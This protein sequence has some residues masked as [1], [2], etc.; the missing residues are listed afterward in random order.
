MSDQNFGIWKNKTKEG[1][2]YLSGTLPVIGEFKLYDNGEPEAG[3]KRPRYSLKISGGKVQT[4][5][6]TPP[7][8][9]EEIPF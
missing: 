3:S 2:D 7:S 1:K 8:K 6:F 5:N 4:V 9:D